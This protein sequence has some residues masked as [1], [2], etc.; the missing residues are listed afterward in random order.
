MIKVVFHIIN[1]ATYF[2]ISSRYIGVIISERQHIYCNN[3]ASICR[4]I[5]EVSEYMKVVLINFLFSNGLLQ[6]HAKIIHKN[7]N[8]NG[9]IR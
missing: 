1:I 8:W 3:I 9:K 2:L 7:G 5:S 6:I 4:I